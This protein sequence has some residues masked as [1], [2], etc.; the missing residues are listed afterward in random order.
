MSNLQNMTIEN[1]LLLAMAAPEP[2]HDICVLS[3]GQPSKICTTTLSFPGE[4]LAEDQV[5]M[6][7]PCDHR[8]HRYH[9]HPGDRTAK[10]L[11][12]SSLPVRDHTRVWRGG[13]QH[14]DTGC[15]DPGFP[16]KGWDHHHHRPGY[17]NQ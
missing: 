6:G 11:G 7:S 9:C 1:K 17:R 13:F 16:N 2:D 5:C 8:I 15:G 3:S 4:S 10:S 12:S 14:P